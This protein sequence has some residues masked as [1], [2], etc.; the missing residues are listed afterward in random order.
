MYRYYWGL[1]PSQAWHEAIVQGT[2]EHI[3]VHEIPD[4]KPVRRWVIGRYKK[5]S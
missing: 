4:A 1:G 3:A 5:K 2:V